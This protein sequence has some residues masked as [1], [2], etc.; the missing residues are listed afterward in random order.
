MLMS[1]DEVVVRPLTLEA[2]LTYKNHPAENIPI[3][4]AIIDMNR[5]D[6]RKLTTRDNRILTTP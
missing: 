2:P 6:N 4:N 5:N 3:A 1:F